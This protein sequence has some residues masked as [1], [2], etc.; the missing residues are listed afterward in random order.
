MLLILHGAQH[1]AANPGSYMTL[2]VMGTVGLDDI[3]FVQCVDVL[4]KMTYIFGG[5]HETGA[6]GGLW[7]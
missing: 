6:S 5:W 2:V 1:P 3:W 4:C 7:R